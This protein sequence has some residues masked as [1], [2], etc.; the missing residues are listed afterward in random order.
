[1]KKTN[2]ILLYSGVFALCIIL[3]AAFNY[4]KIAYYFAFESTFFIQKGKL[5]NEIKSPDKTYTAMVYWDES[6][7][8]L[9]V[10]AKKNI[11][12]NRMIYWSWH[13]TQTD[14]KWIDNYKIIINGKTLD[15]RKDK[16]D[17]RT[18]K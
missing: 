8:A 9:R 11:L 15:V 1:M 18:D 12:Q 5:V 7:G 2:K 14:V 16:Y 17:K 13:E 4:K 3:I 6:D 10:D